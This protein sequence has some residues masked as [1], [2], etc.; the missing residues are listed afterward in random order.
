MIFERL[1]IVGVGLIGGSFAMA[2][3]EAGLA[4]RI[5]GWDDRATLEEALRR[6]LIDEIEESFAGGGF[7]PADLIYLAAPVGGILDFLQTHGKQVKRGAIVTD[8]GSTKRQVCGAARTAITE[9]A[10]FIGGHPMAGSHERGL[11]N[12]RAGLFRDSAYAL[13]G[14]D[15]VP[16]GLDAVALRLFIEAVRAIG[17]RP[18]VMSAERHDHVVAAISHA[19]QVLA[20][21]LAVSVADANDEMM[22]QL[23]GA[24][25]ADMTRLAA[26]HWS[27]WEDICATNG[28]EIAAALGRII[29]TLETLRGELAAGGG[30][31]QT[32]AAFRRANELMRR[33]EK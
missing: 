2:A 29:G 13:I 32:G 9:G 1:A 33:A 26:S 11:A 8:A 28:D 22:P 14:E 15:P 17:A 25:F 23:A 21:A 5:S 24:G 4:R 10:T 12:A 31:T 16:K 20:T 6:G 3:K 18:V 30:L 19:P 7:C 27:V